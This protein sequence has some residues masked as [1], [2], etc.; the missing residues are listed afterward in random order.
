MPLYDYRCRACSKVTE[1]R[2]A[3]REAYQGTCPACGSDQLARVFNPAGI[4]FKG[5]GFYLTD[6]RKQ[7][8]A[9]A[10]AGKSS[11]GKSAEAKS[12]DA[13]SS[14]GSTATSPAPAATPSDAGSKKSDA[15]AA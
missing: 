8:E 1:V 10:S 6:S 9:K 7:A 15:S 2:H 5:S 11:D 13:K 4:V 3:F 12:S 14:E